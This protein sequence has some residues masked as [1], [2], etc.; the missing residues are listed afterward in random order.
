MH[1]VP[2]MTAGMDQHY[3]LIGFLGVM[4]CAMLQ[5]VPIA[6]SSGSSWVMYSL[7]LFDSFVCPNLK[8]DEERPSFRGAGIPVGSGEQ[9]LRSGALNFGC[10]SGSPAQLIVRPGPGNLK[11]T[12]STPPREM[13]TH[14]NSWISHV[15]GCAAAGFGSTS[16]LLRP[17]HGRVPLV[18]F[19]AS[20][21][22]NDTYIRHVHLP[23]A[24]CDEVRQ[25]GVGQQV[26]HHN[27]RSYQV[28]T[29]PTDHGKHGLMH[30]FG[31]Y[32]TM[33]I[34]D[35]DD[36]LDGAW[37]LFIPFH[38]TVA[39]MHSFL[40]NVM[41]RKAEVGV[42]G[43]P[44][45]TWAVRWCANFLRNTG[46]L[47]KPA[48]TDPHQH[49]YGECA[50]GVGHGLSN[51]GHQDVTCDSMANATFPLLNS[52]TVPDLEVDMQTKITLFKFACKFGHRHHAR[53]WAGRRS[54]FP[55]NATQWFERL[56]SA[57]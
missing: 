55:A 53:N 7:L 37:E 40:S 29:D 52:T 11:R 31:Q 48:V 43:V 47:V 45:L 15:W 14:V 5:S 23:Q 42:N 46:F 49:F 39:P 18:K 4:T 57:V 50:H 25:A 33:R 13:R 30:E 36:A 27:V 38:I 22:S 19:A 28:A 32:Y 12:V 16:F 44:I 17:E 34:I 20:G 1:A 21:H 41:K 2:G 6:T 26:L 9:R 24:A 3:P 35:N 54:P 10:V 8:G 51:M 56:R